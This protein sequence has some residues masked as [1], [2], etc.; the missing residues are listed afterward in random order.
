[1][2]AEQSVAWSSTTNG[3]WVNDR[4]MAIAAISFQSTFVILT[5]LDLC[6]VCFW[7]DGHN[8]MLRKGLHLMR[9][10]TFV[11]GFALL[12]AYF[13]TGD[14]SS[15]SVVKSTSGGIPCIDAELKACNMS[16][17]VAF[18][19]SIMF[20]FSA[21]S[22]CMCCVE[23]VD[24]ADET[25]GKGDKW[26]LQDEFDVI[27]KLPEEYGSMI[28]ALSL[29][30]KKKKKK[31]MGGADTFES[32]TRRRPRPQYAYTNATDRGLVSGLTDLGNEIHPNSASLDN[33]T[34]STES[35]DEENHRAE[36]KTY[37]KSGNRQTGSWSDGCVVQ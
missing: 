4:P 13:Q 36:Q 1:M 20:L 37:T 33:D 31:V 12:I 8:W 30:K 15:K 5:A 28:E 10:I 16:S 32:K 22:C 19:A 25:S 23:T 11:I 27:K 3:T 29:K 7:K 9:F 34:S 26:T 24:Y 2:D 18:M 35:T 6:L 17:R 21:F 14:V